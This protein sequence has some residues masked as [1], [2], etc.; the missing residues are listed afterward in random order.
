MA[1]ENHLSVKAHSAVLH[2][3]YRGT[4]LQHKAWLVLLRNAA[5]ELGDDRVKKHTMGV[6]ALCSALGYTD[7]PNRANLKKT[8]TG[9]QTLTVSYNLFHKDAEIWESFSML[10]GVRLHKG[11]ITYDFSQIM[12]ERLRDPRVFTLLNISVLSRFRSKYSLALYNT[13]VDYRGVRQTPWMGLEVFREL[14][15]IEEHE[16]PDYKRLSQ[17]VI[18][19]AIGEVNAVSD[20]E[21]EPEY[22]KASRTITHIK[23]HIRDKRQQE[24]SLDQAPF[25]EEDVASLPAASDGLRVALGARGLNAKQIADVLD[26]FDAE[27]IQAT[28]GYVDAQQKSRPKTVKNEA[29]YLLAALRDRYVDQARA[30]EQG[31]GGGKRIGQSRGS[32]EATEQLAREQR[33]ELVRK[34]LSALTRQGRDELDREFVRYIERNS[35][36]TLRV[37]LERFG[38]DA[39]LLREEFQQFAARKLLAAS[40]LAPPSR[41]AAQ[42][43]ATRSARVAATK[44]GSI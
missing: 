16:Y 4:L 31:R 37:A 33:D 26:R 24:L 35:R 7:D 10:A 22:K 21:V 23:F 9:L 34:K 27:Y 14:M 38:V 40:D 41:T 20:I 25:G 3:S 5:H 19:P 43:P 44:D 30:T 15:G 13:C 29:A 39:P 12:R 11:V 8:L 32:R 42:R 36:R 2:I 1:K 18:R 28:L 6:S 17:R